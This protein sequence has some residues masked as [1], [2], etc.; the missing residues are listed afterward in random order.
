MQTALRTNVDLV[1]GNKISLAYSYLYETRK[2]IRLRSS[3]QF[4]TYNLTLSSAI[5]LMCNL[6]QDATFKSLKRELYET[7]F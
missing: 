4:R 3:K 6:K 7:K 5:S 2:N 1:K